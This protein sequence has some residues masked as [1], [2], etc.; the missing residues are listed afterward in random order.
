[1]IC[2]SSHRISLRLTRVLWFL[3]KC[4]W[5]CLLFLSENLIYSPLVICY[6]L[7][8]TGNELLFKDSS[9]QDV[10]KNTCLRWNKDQFTNSTIYTDRKTNRC[11]GLLII[12]QPC[13]CHGTLKCRFF[14]K[15]PALLMKTVSGFIHMKILMLTVISKVTSTVSSLILQIISQLHCFMF[16]CSF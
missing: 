7:S 12:S 16:W 3:L 8:T 13:L 15:F 9:H 11:I 4:I 10:L 1:M 6:S 14:T 2:Y 5:F